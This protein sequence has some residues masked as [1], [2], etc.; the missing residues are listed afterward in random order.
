M[1]YAEYQI[2]V[3]A[4]N[5]EKTRELRLYRRQLYTTI[6]APYQ[7]AKKIPKTEQMFMPLFGDSGKEI[8]IPQSVIDRFNDKMKKYQDSKHERRTITTDPS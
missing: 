2:R 1:S 4:Y 7:D 6:I 5:R 8:T 3:F